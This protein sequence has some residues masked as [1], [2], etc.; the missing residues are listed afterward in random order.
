MRRMRNHVRKIAAVVAVFL[1]AVILIEADF[2][3]T[4]S[5]ARADSQI[6]TTTASR[7]DEAF[8]REPLVVV[9]LR[10]TDGINKSLLLQELEIALSETAHLTTVSEEDALDNTP[11]LMASVRRA[12]YYLPVYSD[13]QLQVDWYYASDGDLEGLLRGEPLTFYGDE[14]PVRRIKGETS[15]NLI[16]YGFFTSRNY[17]RSLAENLAS[18]LTEQLENHLSP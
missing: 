1:A 8:R 6:S 7:E 12:G 5:T 18:E 2:G 17:A 9:E 13:T 14:E 10:R 11:V 3:I 16:M 15:V 4:F